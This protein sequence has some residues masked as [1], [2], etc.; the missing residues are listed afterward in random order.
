MQ[1]T[2]KFIVA[3]T[4]AVFLIAGGSA[5]V[6]A[7]VTSGAPAKVTAERALE[8]AGGAV[9]GGWVED[10]SFDRRGAEPDVWE[11]NVVKGDV[12][13]ELDIDAASGKVLSNT[14]DRD[15]DQDD[16]GKDD[17]RDDDRD[18]NAQSAQNG[19]N[20]QNDRDDRDDGKDDD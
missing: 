8:I 9:A 20:G 17:D 6:A 13:H 5:A 15:D 7:T 3:G 11:V 10:L 1:I 18:G 4:G 14:I 2:K 16:D 19:Q 12:E